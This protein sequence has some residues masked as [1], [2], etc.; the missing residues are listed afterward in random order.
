MTLQKKLFLSMPIPIF[1]ATCYFVHNHPTYSLK[2]DKLDQGFQSHHKI[3]FPPS[4]ADS[5]IRRISHPRHRQGCRRLG[6]CNGP[7]LAV[8]CAVPALRHRRFDRRLAGNLGGFHLGDLHHGPME[9]DWFRRM[10]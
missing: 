9:K 7:A 8:G 2:M 5:Q 4:L 3:P 6:L 1:F 10:V